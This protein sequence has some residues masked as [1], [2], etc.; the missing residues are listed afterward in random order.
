M[1]Y[2]VEDLPPAG[3]TKSKAYALGGLLFPKNGKLSGFALHLELH[4]LQR[5]SSSS[6][7]PETVKT[8][9]YWYSRWR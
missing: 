9:G 5:L 4:Y 1:T 7:S 2:E 6:F 8:G 3:I